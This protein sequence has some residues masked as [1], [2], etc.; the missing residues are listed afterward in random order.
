MGLSYSSYLRLDELLALQKPVSDGPE[1]DEILFIVIH[2]VYE[3]WFKQ[4]LH[5]T[6]LLQLA[7]ENGHTP[8]VTKTLKRVLTILKTLVAQIDI[9][10]TMT[11]VSFTSLRERLQTASGFQSTQ[12]RELEFVLGYRRRAIVD[13]LPEGS[14]AKQRLERLLGR[15]SVYD[16]FLRYLAVLGYPIPRDILERDL[17]GPHQESPAV[18]ES[19]IEI[20]GHDP[21]A[22]Q[23]CE[24]MTD[25]DK[26]LQEWRYRHGVMVERTIGNKRS[27]ADSD[28]VA[29]LK[30][31]LAKVLFP[32]LWAIRRAL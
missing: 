2:Q 17:S 28:G 12:F 25:L 21:G 9:L 26:V 23:V 10:E 24:L 19:L 16:S 18:Q 14:V 11:P 31:T 3:L 4:I 22:Q 7:M 15:P 1:H 13:A 6:K 32:D 29:Y 5:E 8:I 30:S 27:A 20:Y